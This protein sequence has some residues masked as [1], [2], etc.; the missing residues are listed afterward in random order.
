LGK[1]I[2]GCWTPS[3]AT[4]TMVPPLSAVTETHNHSYYL[5]IKVFLKFNQMILCWYVL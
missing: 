2:G 1:W 5:N 4:S 3:C